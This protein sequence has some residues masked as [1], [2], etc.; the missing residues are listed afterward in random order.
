MTRIRLNVQVNKYFHDSVSANLDQFYIVN[1]LSPNV[2]VGNIQSK[3]H[4]YSEY[5]KK[6]W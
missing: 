4:K 2:V 6:S 5:V 1:Q 3:Y